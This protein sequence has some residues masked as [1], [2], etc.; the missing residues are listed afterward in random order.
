M[1]E[2]IENV[3]FE[4]EAPKLSPDD[5]TE[6]MQIYTEDEAFAPPVSDNEDT[7]AEGIA[8]SDENG[9]LEA[10]RQTVA[11]LKETIAELERTRDAQAKVIQDISDF[12]ALFPE[13]ALECIPDAVWEDVK[14]GIPLAASYAL[15][16][17]KMKAEQIKA[18]RINLS[19][20]SRSPGVAGKD[21]ASEY[22]SP[23]DV[24]KMSQAEVHSNY[25]KIKR[26]MKTWM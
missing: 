9:E 24:R 18:D 10:L 16:E 3:I 21:T 5:M 4:K 26:S 19:N 20:A 15:Y 25:A 8:E 17:R 13:V 7:I 6:D 12:S 2:A 14:N 22:F 1:T 11:S 23:D